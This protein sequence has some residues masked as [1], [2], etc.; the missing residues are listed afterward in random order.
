MLHL[1]EFIRRALNVLANLVTVG[2]PMEK[3]PQD[4]HV[5]RSLQ[6]PDP[7]LCL[8]CHR[9][10]STLNLRMMVGIRLSIVKFMQAIAFMEDD[11]CRHI[12]DIGAGFWECCSSSSPFPV[13][14]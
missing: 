7:L 1:Q 9:R 5:E 10:H 12:G 13:A 3:R 14:W 2:R 6:E 4:E 11:C 8:L